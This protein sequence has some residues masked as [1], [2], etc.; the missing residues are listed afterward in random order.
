MGYR[1]APEVNLA[2]QRGEVHGRAGETFNTMMLNSGQ[3]VRDGKLNILV[4]IGGQKE[5]GFENVPLL[6]D[7]AT[8]EPG[9]Q[10]LQLFSDE[11]SLGRP[12]LAPADVPADRLQALRASFE[13]TLKDSAFLE[14][15]KAIKL[16]VAP[17]TGAALETTVARMLSLKGDILARAKAAMESDEGATKSK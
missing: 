11:I 9:R 12:Y 3:L 13:A 2:V 10:V 7:F 5:K 6:T 16:D 8:D 14:D 4:Q 15:A 1:S 17:A